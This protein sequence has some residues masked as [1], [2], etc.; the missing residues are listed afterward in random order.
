MIM[1]SIGNDSSSVSGVGENGSVDDSK[2]NSIYGGS[3]RQAARAGVVQLQDLSPR[4]TGAFFNAASDFDDGYLDSMAVTAAAS[5]VFGHDG[6]DDNGQMLIP[7][8]SPSEYEDNQYILDGA[9][10]AA[11][12]NLFPAECCVERAS[13]NRR[14]RT[15]EPGGGGSAAGYYAAAGEGRMSVAGHDEAVF[16]PDGLGVRVATRHST[17]SSSS[18]SSTLSDD[19]AGAGAGDVAGGAVSHMSMQRH[20]RYGRTHQHGAYNGNNFRGVSAPAPA[21]A[22]VL[23]PASASASSLALGYESAEERKHNHDAALKSAADLQRDIFPLGVPSQ[24]VVKSG[25]QHIAAD[26][27]FRAVGCEDRPWHGFI[28]D[29]VLFMLVP[30]F[31]GSEGCFRTAV[32]AL[33]E[34]AEDVLLCSSV[35]IALPR[36]LGTG[37]AAARDAT[38]TAAAATLVRAFMY[39][40]FELV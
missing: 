25:Q 16:V 8:P 30:E 36:A 10:A 13:A 33:M 1:F 14:E 2:P 38:A 24:G 28:L 32:M 11:Y 26:V 40:G 7:E 27:L 6:H 9:S 4:S 21:P 29:D 15:I 20:A 3:V 23:M 35:I 22:T 31:V 19:G 39:S 5:A 12:N 37:A 17:R 18:S 34:L